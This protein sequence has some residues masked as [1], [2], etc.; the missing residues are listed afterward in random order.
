MNN[1]K[2]RANITAYYPSNEGVEGGYLDPLGKP[3]K[4]N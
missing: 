4:P 3:L 1:M 2:I